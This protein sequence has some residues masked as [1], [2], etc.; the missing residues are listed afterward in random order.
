MKM[1]IFSMKKKKKMMK[2]RKRKKK[3]KIIRQNALKKV[4]NL[5]K[6]KKP[7]R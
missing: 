6:M 3:F 5:G 2:K 1:M 7:D 4:V